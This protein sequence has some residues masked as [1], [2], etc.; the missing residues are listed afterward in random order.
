MQQL[1]K[2]LFNGK[3]PDRGI[4]PHGM[5]LMVLPRRQLSSVV[6][7]IRACCLLLLHC[8]LLQTA[9]GPREH[10]CFAKRN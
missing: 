6:K 4:K 2:D 3:A 9:F 8:T 5:W 7:V 10:D 1:I